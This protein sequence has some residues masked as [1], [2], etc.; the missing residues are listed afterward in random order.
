MYRDLAR[1]CESRLLRR[2]S[3][4]ASALE[5]HKN[6]AICY[7]D[8]LNFARRTVLGVIACIALAT[9]CEYQA[10]EVLVVLDTDAPVSRRLTLTVTVSDDAP[11]SHAPRTWTRDMN[12]HDTIALP[13]SF[14]IVPT[15]DGPRNG[16]VTLLVEA[17]V[18]P[19][20]VGEPELVYRRS[21]RF[22]FLPRQPSVLRMFLPVACGG[23]AIGCHAPAPVRCTQSVLCEEQG[24]TCGLRLYNSR[25]PG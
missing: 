9:G 5:W 6:R 8:T 12:S 17:R 25:S 19:G 11:G 10:T 3:T 21:A 7:D 13:A 22:Q 15:A 24:L 23:A 2:R 20:R 4:V 18:A 1:S 16:P 14:A